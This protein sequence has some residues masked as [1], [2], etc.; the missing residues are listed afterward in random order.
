MSLS[1]IFQS[2]STYP[3][4][5][6]KNSVILKIFVFD[7]FCPLLTFLIEKWGKADSEAFRQRL[8]AL[9]FMYILFEYNF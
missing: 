3:A 7:S 1:F 6:C 4:V 9:I 2:N 8:L 5:G